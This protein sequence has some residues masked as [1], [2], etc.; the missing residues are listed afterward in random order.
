MR[1]G[2]YGLALIA[3]PAVLLAEPPRLG[4]PLDCTLGADCY[5]EDYVD[6]R[7]GKGQADYACGLKS[8]DGHTGIDF[9]LLSF[10]QMRAGVDV[11]ASAPGI[12]RGLRDGVDDVAVTDDNRAAIKGIE[13]GNGVVIRH[14][15]GWETQYCHLKKGTVAVQQGQR[16]LRGTV[17]GQVGLSGQTNFPHVHLRVNKDRENVD[18]FDPNSDAAETCSLTDDS[19]WIDPPDYAAAGLFSA[20]FTS[21]VP[22]LKQVQS[23]SQVLTSA[24]TDTPALVL[25]GHA[26][27]TKA[28][29]VMRI[30]ITGPQGTVIAKAV[31]LEKDRAQLFRAIGKKRPAGGW[32][33]GSYFGQVILERA[34]RVL[35]VRL[36]QVTI[37]P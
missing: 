1:A 18:P 11:I 35:A 28:G 5:I 3:C 7:P 34:D 27:H 19:L 16:V 9:A 26:F 36:T 6:A 4:L 15:D 25:S 12:V 33:T 29:D 31:Q 32:P 2:A 21:F 14:L 10:D 17:L 22:T 20:D 24:S 13:C 37:S 23:R 30:T 8:R